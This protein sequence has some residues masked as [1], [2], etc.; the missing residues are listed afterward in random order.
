MKS[1]NI[2]FEVCILAV[3]IILLSSSVLAF[4][5][6]APYMPKGKSGN[7]QLFLSPGKTES[8]TFVVQNGG[9]VTTDVLVKVSLKE[10]SEIATIVDTTEKTVPGGGRT[11]FTVRVSVPSD[12]SLDT[13]YHVVLG[14]ATGDNGNGAF[15]FGSSI[16]HK[17]DVVVGTAPP[18]TPMNEGIVSPS[19]DLQSESP[20]IGETAF[21]SSVLLLVTIVVALLIIIIIYLI[22]SRLKNKKP[23]SRRK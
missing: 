6:S 7:P 10:G 21:S 15:S 18:E 1:A 3:F 13:V 12:A 14:F 19:E 23:R 8:L 5:V 22:L 20:Q 16:G 4:A 17:F 9:G 2:Y 11:E